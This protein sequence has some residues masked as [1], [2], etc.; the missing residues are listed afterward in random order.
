MEILINVARWVGILVVSLGSASSLVAQD[1]PQTAPKADPPKK[2]E[3]QKPA[4]DKAKKKDPPKKEAKKKQPKKIKPTPADVMSY[5]LQAG[6]SPDGKSMAFVWAGDIWVGATK[7][8][9]VRRLTQHPAQEWTPKFSPDGKEIAF[10]SEREGSLQVYVVPAKGG[11]PTKITDHTEGY[12]LLGWNPD[13]KSLMARCRRDQLGKRSSRLFSVPRDTIGGDELL[14]DAEADR[15]VTSPDGKQILFTRE[16]VT[17][18]RKGYHGSQAS[19]IWL[20]DIATKKFRELIREPGGART[21]LWKPDG[22]GFYYTA[23]R[24]GAFNLYS[25]DLKSGKDRQLTTFEGDGV[26]RPSLSR[27]GKVLVF[28]RGFD[29]YRL[30]L[31]AEQMVAKK[32]IF[33]H[34]ADIEIGGEVRRLLKTATEVSF[35]AD[36]LEIA[37]ISG[38]EVWVMDTVLRAPK[39]VTHTAAEESE[40]MFSKDGEQLYYL[41]DNG[42][43]CNLWRAKRMDT[44]KFWW[45]NTH[46]VQEPITKGAD[47]ISNFNPSRDGKRIAYIK[48]LGDLWIADI[49]GKNADRILEAWAMPYYDWSPDGRWLVYSIYD[50][51]F[52]RDVWIAPVDGS[53]LPY[54]LSRHPDYDGAPKWSPDGKVIAFTG[55]RHGEETD[56]YY[57]WLQKQNDEQSSRDRSEAKALAAM[58]ARPKKPTPPK[59]PDPKATAKP[60]DKPKDETPFKGLL[61]GLKKIAEQSEAKEKEKAKT[62]TPPKKPAPQKTTSTVKIDFDGLS[63][64]LRRV[65]I[66][67]AREGGLLWSPSSKKLAFSAQIKGVGALYSIEFPDKLAPVPL[68]PKQLSSI[69]WLAK[70]DKLVWLERGVPGSLSKGKYAS[71]P[72]SAAQSYQQ[73]EKFRVA[74]LQIWRAMRDNYYD[75]ALG[76]NDWDKIREKYEEPAVNAADMVAFESIASMLLG[77]LNGSHLGFRA[78]SSFKPQPDTGGWKRETVHLGAQFR[79]EG[80]QIVVDAVIPKSPA[81]RTGSKLYAGDVI[82]S[83]DGIDVTNH[84]QLLQALN[85]LPG[86][87]VE[88]VVKRDGKDVPPVSIPSTSYGMA[89]VLL[90]NAWVEQNRR[91]VEK[92]SGGRLGYLYVARM[93]WNEF[94]NFER[95]IY[96]VGAGKDG[97][98]IDVR[99]NGGGFTADHLLTVLTPPEHAFTVPRGGGIGYPGDRRVYGVWGKPITVLCNQ[100]SFSNAEI[101]SHAVKVLGRGK[102]VGVPTAGGVI[103]TGGT[104]IMDM[105]TLRL[106]FRGWYKL[107][108]GEDME[109]NGA[110]PDVILWPKPGDIPAGT[111]KQLEKAVQVLKADVKKFQATP[112]P[113]PRKASDR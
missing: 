30:Q 109:L 113:K 39:Q 7:G 91:E 83:V 111:D 107:D 16:G 105:G 40:I 81:D 24:G 88:V 13:G 110:I 98:I 54:N 41:S 94:E 75:G 10:V 28:R 12:Y 77:E 100:N 87:K 59:K 48:G 18:Y 112:R 95:E 67:D 62:P 20:Y 8:G 57:V 11:V 69:N 66:P 34:A 31:D 35:S 51:D 79:S 27:D 56:I 84:S 52:N 60:D 2:E 36:G 44:K 99:D 1:K 45:Q 37:F 76:G 90:K 22:S 5:G 78:S 104:T 14:F 38:G 6:I 58:K 55:R 64:R 3:P 103:S 86:R 74:F 102:V 23:Q 15:G 21:P 19:Q 53:M 71:Y 29:F 4:A 82:V 26:I 32:I 89:R 33:R 42:T 68:V 97:I 63:D 80:G 25:R 73:K 70:N 49:D 106:P 108:D 9:R 47:I 96:A 85:G 50:N 43:E 93:M 92:L 72:F 17:L 46:F 65:S 101:F 61:A